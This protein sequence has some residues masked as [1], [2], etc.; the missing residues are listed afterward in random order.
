MINEIEKISIKSSAPTIEAVKRLDQDISLQSLFVVD[1]N[2]R[3]IGLFRREDL[4]SI[5]LSKK[6]FNSPVADYINPDF[7]KLRE[8]TNHNEAAA[9]ALGAGSVIPVVD[10]KDMLLGYYHPQRE[11]GLKGSIRDYTVNVIGMGFVG[12][13]L[14]TQL[15]DTGFRVHG[16][17]IKQDVID[18]LNLA[19]PHFHEKGLKEYLQMHA[20]KNLRFS[21]ELNPSNLNIFIISV[22]TPINKKTGKPIIDHVRG[23]AEEIG[24]VLRR[25]NLIV[26]R[27]TAPVKTIK[28]VV[29]PVLS[30]FSGLKAGIDYFVASAPERT[31]EG[32]ALKELRTNPQIVGGI[33]PASCEMAIKLFSYLTRTI[34]PVDSVEAAEMC[35]LIDN[36]YRDYVFAYSN[37]LAMLTEQ[38]GLDLTKLVEAVN[39]QYP[40]NNVPKPSPGVGGPCLTKDPYIMMELFEEN[41]IKSKLFHESRIINES[42]A[43]H[44]FGKIQNL[45]KSARKEWKKSK[46]FIAGFAFKGQP[47]TSDL[48]DSTTLW[49]LDLLKETGAR[50]VGFDPVVPDDELAALGI[51]VVNEFKEGARD[52]DAILIMNNHRS[53]YNLD[54]S[55][56]LESAARPVVFVDSWHIF[57][58]N[59]IKQLPE[60]ILAGVG[61]D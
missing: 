58:P 25:G 16:N 45:F 26:M 10:G 49:L 14:A 24:K 44:L 47:E 33:N 19:E 7:P 50:L 9:L 37:Q 23:A 27:S 3:L 12:L 38:M 18:K 6:G 5:I 8:G 42:G 43:H 61:N 1:A 52:A 28:D 55:T 32:N 13:T 31:I 59:Y 34:I 39:Y 4:P 20:G 60:V 15:A 51:E 41:G 29:I 48:R 57:E 40:R 54:I 22:S 30:R 2:N 17:D 35:K 21:T 11:N 36:T 56:L 46:I 53:F